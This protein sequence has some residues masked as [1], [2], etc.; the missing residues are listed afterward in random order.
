MLSIRSSPSKGRNPD[1]KRVVRKRGEDN[2]KWLAR[3][4]PKDDRPCLVLLGGTGPVD[5]RLRVALSHARHD[6]TPS[7]WS[8]VV[9]LDV[10]GR[11]LSGAGGG[12]GAK[13]DP[14]AAAITEIS[15]EPAGGFGYP[16]QTNGVQAAALARYRDPRLWPNAALVYLPLDLAEVQKTVR[17]F[18]YQ[19]AAL[20]AVDL[21]LAWL[22]YVWGT[23]RA[24]NPLVE[25]RGIPSATMVEYVL[26]G[27]Q[28]ELTPGLDSRSSCPEAIWQSA[29]WWHTYYE[30]SGGKK[31]EGAWVVDHGLVDAR[32]LKG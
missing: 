21:V 9:L 17:R 15:L 2:L 23:G 22:A 31:L 20:D 26:G 28:Y 27:L 6:L 10:P 30:Q 8:H 19:R 7:H 18:M 5:F 16:P 29:L 25:G 12:G 1:F 13:A 11:E 24:T 14:G 4:A 32:P 3:N